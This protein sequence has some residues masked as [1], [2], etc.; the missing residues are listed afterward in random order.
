MAAWR[1]CC[2]SGARRAQVGLL[3]PGQLVLVISYTRM[4]YKPIR[5]LTGEGKRESPRPRHVRG[6]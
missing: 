4:I 1:W 3:T 5:K 2:W 6:G